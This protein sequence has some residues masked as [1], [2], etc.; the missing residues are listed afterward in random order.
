M[1]SSVVA[2]REDPLDIHSTLGGDLVISVYDLPSRIPSEMLQALSRE[3][4]RTNVVLPHLEKA[5]L[6]E[7][8]GE[9]DDN[10]LWITCTSKDDKGYRTPE[11]ILSCTRSELGEYPIFIAPLIPASFLTEEFL[12]PRLRLLMIAMNE[13]IQTGRVYS[14]F[15][16]Q[17]VAELFAEMWFDMK[18]IDHYSESYYAAKLTFCTKR[19]FRNRQ[20]TDAGLRGRYVLR[21]AV[22][23]DLEGVAQ[24]CFQFASESE[25]FILDAEGALREAQMLIVNKQVWV[26]ELQPNPSLPP[27]TPSSGSQIA[28]L[29]AF[30]RN[31]QTCATISKVVTSPDH[32]G[33]G[34]AQRLMRQVC[35]HL[36][37]SGKQAVALYVAH[38][39]VPAT[40]VYHNV[41]FVGL[42]EADNQPIE[43]VER[44]SEIGF[45]RNRVQLGHW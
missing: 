4:I 9:I 13:H 12:V 22:M 24:L 16:P 34:C 17:L 30:T 36:L 42:G 43:G 40:K 3:A 14:I 29:V 26:H 39:N 38:N 41:G 2:N 20:A 35:K 10:Q 37:N 27:S 44:W 6:R 11:L 21:P 1:N 28:C 32:R 19:T 5:R 45:D 8:T 25:P 31:S 33:M 18:G 23:T 15:A 7:D